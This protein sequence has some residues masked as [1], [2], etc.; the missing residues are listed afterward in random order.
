MAMA[1]D[2][3]QFRD[4]ISRVLTDLGLCSDSAVE[5]LL[6]TAAQESGFGTYLQQIKG[7]AR[8]VFQMEPATERDIWDNFLCFN[9]RLALS[10][11]IRDLSGAWRGGCDSFALEGNLIYQTAMC[12]VHYL[13]V[14]SPLPAANDLVALANYWKRHYNTF[15][16]KGTP[17]E[18]VRN[19]HQY[20]RG[21]R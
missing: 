12:R 14:P 11:R 7:P 1:F 4:F 2:P 16:G 5:L 21:E 19:Y 17:Q 8:G 15:Q 10:H 18:F 9:D 20:V 3:S 6:G 13:R